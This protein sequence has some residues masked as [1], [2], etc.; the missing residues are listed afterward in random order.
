MR[1]FR[2]WRD[3]LCVLACA[4][5]ALNR[6]VVAPHSASPFLHNYFNDLLLIPAALPFLL[7]VQH[8]LAL[9]PESGPPT[10]A[11][12]FSHLIIWTIICEVIGPRIFPHAIG[13]RFDALAYAIGALLAWGWW[14]YVP[15]PLTDEF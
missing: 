8:K 12:V 10:F 4:A 2:F 13:D 3:S 6:W 14:S 5:Y 15:P 7:W 1:P 11:E 9:R